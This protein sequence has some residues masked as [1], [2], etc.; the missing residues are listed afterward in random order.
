MILPM[1]TPFT[2][3]CTIHQEL[4]Y[5]FG[6]VCQSPVLK[7]RKSFEERKGERRIEIPSNSSMSTSKNV[8]ARAAAGR[9]KILY[10]A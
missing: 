8:D 1:F 3:T 7:A 4:Q 2:G 6:D 5:H 10:C 9:G